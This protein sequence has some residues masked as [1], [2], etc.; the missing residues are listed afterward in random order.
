MFADGHSWVLLKGG[1]RD[2]KTRK[3]ALGL[4]KALWDND[5]EWSRTGHLP[6]RKSVAESAAYRELPFRAN[7][8]EIATTAYSVPS[9]V[10]RQ[11]AVETAMGEEISSMYLAKKPLADVQTAIEQRV[12][13]LLAGAN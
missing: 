12:G 4:L 10:P 3:A 2:D 7:I 6:A 5:F 11:R 1:T 9:D 8:A 13:K